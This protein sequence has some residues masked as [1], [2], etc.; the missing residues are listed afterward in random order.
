MMGAEPVFVDMLGRIR[1]AARNGTRLHLDPEHVAALLDADIYAVLSAR[2][3]E[4]IRTQ[5][6]PE[7]PPQPE[8]DDAPPASPPMLPPA[9]NLAPSGS[10]IGA[11]GTTGASAG[12][13]AVSRAAH[14]RVSEVAKE[15]R[16]KK[17]KS[18]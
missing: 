2:E 6:R 7:R 14:R 1:R 18:A 16:R 13:M 8:L 12:S 10:G 5:C 4:E 3:A 17:R 9:L 11:I 15:I